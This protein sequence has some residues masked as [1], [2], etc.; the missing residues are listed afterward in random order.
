[1]IEGIVFDLDG[2]LINSEPLWQEAEIELFATEGLEITR[3]DCKK[4]K[5]LPSCEVV[6]YWHAKVKEPKKEVPLLTQELNHNVIELLK[7]KVE[8]KLGVIE[9]LDF[10][11]TKKLPMGIA[12]ASSMAHIKAVL[13]KFELNNYFNLIYSG[14]FERFGKPHP[15]IYIS[16]CKK[17]K[18]NPVCSLAIE[19]SFNG[20]LAA[21]SARMKVIALLDEGQINETIYDFA[22]LKIE[23]FPD[24]NQ[25]KFTFL[26]A[27]CN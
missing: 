7:E 27:L 15:G 24:F 5:G 18:I 1:M 23:R 16:A 26:E 12:S 20:I 21:K 14:D 10:C 19:D 13:D 9:M 4:T 25:E 2:T 11:K 22:D 17:L 3:E 8:L 6:K